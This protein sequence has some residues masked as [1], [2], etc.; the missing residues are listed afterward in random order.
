MAALSDKDKKAGKLSVLTTVAIDGY[1][2]KVT[3]LGNNAFK[4]AAAKGVTL[5]RNITVIPKGAFAGC[6]KLSTLTVNAKLK[7]VKKGAFKGCK[8]KIKVKGGTRKTRKSN[9]AKLKKSGYKKFIL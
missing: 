2:Y 6:K 7:S 9:I 8:K 3:K 4:N 1:K 5:G